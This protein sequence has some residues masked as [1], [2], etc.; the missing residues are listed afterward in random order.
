MILGAVMASLADKL[1]GLKKSDL[2]PKHK[3]NLGN[4]FWCYT[5]FHEN[6]H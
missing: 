3:N 5:N 6:K 1:L 2:E 4:E